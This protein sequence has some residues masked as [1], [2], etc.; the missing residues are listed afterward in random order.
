VAHAVNIMAGEV[1][2]AAVAKTFDL[3]YANRFSL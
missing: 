3:P 2:N 1:T